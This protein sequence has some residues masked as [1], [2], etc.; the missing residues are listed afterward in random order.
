MDVRYTVGKDEYKRMII[1]S[2]SQDIVY[3]PKISGIAANFLLPSL[4]QNGLDPETLK[5]PE[6]IDMGE[7]LNQEAKAWKTIWSAGQGVGGITDIPAAGELCA[8][9]IREYR[10]TCQRLQATI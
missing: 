9:I 5:M 7:E 1:D 8:R 3:T 6:H 2:G 10:S 4:L